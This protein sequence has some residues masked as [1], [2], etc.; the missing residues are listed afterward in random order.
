MNLPIRDTVFEVFHFLWENRTD[1]LRMSAAPVFALSIFHIVLPALFAG[2]TATEGQPNLTGMNILGLFLAIALPTVFYVMFAVAWH[3]RCLRSEEQTTILTALRWES[4]KTLFLL[5]FIMI[6]IISVVA[7]LPILVIGSI[8]GFFTATGMAVGG[9]SGPSASTFEQLA[10][11]AIFLVVMLVQVRLS[12]ILPATALDQKLTLTEAWVMGR[13]NTWR[14]FAVLMMA[15]APAMVVLILI[16]SALTGVA[17]GS[18]LGDTLT[19]QFVV[20]LVFNMAYYIVI[21]TSVSALS[22]SYRKLRQTPSA[23]MPYHM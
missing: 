5:R 17:Q 8:V 7:V 9:V 21:A 14:L 2:Y 3:R 20:R 15:V 13:G 10:K 23:G 11:L 22:I 16:G 6:S 4:R 1:L 18:G 19:F 12:L